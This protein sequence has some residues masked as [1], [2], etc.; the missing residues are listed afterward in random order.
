MISSGR[1]SAQTGPKIQLGSEAERRKM[2]IL[3]KSCLTQEMR[4]LIL[5][6]ILQRM[7]TKGLRLN[8]EGEVGEH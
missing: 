6:K 3:K 4:A 7:W 2:N 1:N 5:K 8:H